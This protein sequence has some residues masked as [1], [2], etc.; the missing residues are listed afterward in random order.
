MQIPP[1][2]PYSSGIGR[3]SQPSAA[4]GL[5]PVAHIEGG[6]GNRKKSGGA[7]VAVCETFVNA[8]TSEMAGQLRRD[9]DDRAPRGLDEDR[10]RA[11]RDRALVLSRR[12]RMVRP[13]ADQVTLIR[14]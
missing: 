3:P 8:A 5:S 12:G 1:M 4:M 11:R 9:G 10:G 7:V 13:N 6:F 14:G 2:P